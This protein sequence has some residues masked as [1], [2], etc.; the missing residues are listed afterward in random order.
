MFPALIESLIESAHHVTGMDPTMPRKATVKLEPDHGESAQVS[1]NGLSPN[2][3]AHKGKDRQLARPELYI[4]REVATVAFIRRV[5]E[6]AS[7][8]AM[9]CWIVSVSC[10]LW[11]ARSMNF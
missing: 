1:A 4:N 8:R 3:N 5:L 10:R 2:G 9:P 7:R 6:E 11:A